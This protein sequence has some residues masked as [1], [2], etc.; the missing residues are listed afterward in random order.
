M[1]H[2]CPIDVLEEGVHFDFLSTSLGTQPPGRIPY[3][4]LADDVLHRNRDS[5]I[6]PGQEYRPLDSGDLQQVSALHQHHRS[7]NSRH[8]ATASSGVQPCLSITGAQT[9]GMRLLQA[10]TS[11]ELDRP[12][13]S[14]CS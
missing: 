6:K 8:A 10:V 4:Q 9:A 13:G 5:K 12:S 14:C 11:V 2:E 3:Q 7:R 1:A